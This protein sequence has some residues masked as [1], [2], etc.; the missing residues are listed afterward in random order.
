MSTIG[1]FAEIR[2]PPR[3]IRCTATFSAFKGAGHA[4][5][6]ANNMV[7]P[8]CFGCGGG[9]PVPGGGTHISEK[10]CCSSPEVRGACQS[11][12]RSIAASSK[13]ARRIPSIDLPR[14]RMPP[15]ILPLFRQR[16]VG[17]QPIPT[18][19]RESACRRESFRCSA[20]V[21]LAPGKFPRAAAN[22]HAA[23]NPSVVPPACRRHSANPPM[24][25]RIRMPPRALPLFRQRAVG[26]RQIPPIPP[27]THA[28]AGCPVSRF[29]VRSLGRAAEFL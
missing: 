22:P 1:S 9:V 18:Y 5:R 3:P 8:H 24:L 28:E 25:P 20:S 17:T 6:R 19:R 14:I 27:R 23:A 11:P 10:R 21:P 26:T 12:A 13:T 7:V 15:R 16:A 2:P 4:V 29:G